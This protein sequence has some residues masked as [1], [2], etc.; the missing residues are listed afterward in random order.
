VLIEF[1]QE[2]LSQ[3]EEECQELIRLHWEEIALNKAKIRLNPDWESYY[4]AEKQGKF[5]VF[6]ARLSGTLVGYFA[7]FIGSNPHYKDHLFAANDVIYLHKD[8]RKGM[9]GV[10]LIKFAEACLKQD[11]V[12]VLSINT[13]T[14]QPFDPI[15]SR[16]GFNLIERVYSKYLGE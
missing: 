8:F 9:T 3:V 15:L 14:H 13:K 7:V 12:S 2:F 16:L 5:K 4:E 6:T 10:K 11:G 1:K